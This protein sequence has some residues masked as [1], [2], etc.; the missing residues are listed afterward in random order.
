M[1]YINKLNAYIINI[2]LNLKE[3]FLKYRFVLLLSFIIGLLINS[4]DI[5]TFKFGI[6]NVVPPYYHFIK[7]RYGSLIL[8]KLFPFLSYNHVS[9]I[10]GVIALILAAL[11]MISKYKF[12]NNAKFLFIITFISAIYF[13]H[14]QYFF[15]QS[16]YNFIG[17]LFAVIAFRLIENNKKIIYHILAVFLLFTGITSYQSN[18]AVFL[19]TLMIGVIL[20][21]IDNKNIKS[22][23]YKI[24]KGIIIL[25]ITILIYYIVMKVTSTGI[26]KS[27]H[28]GMI[29]W[30]HSNADYTQI[31]INLLKFIFK[32]EIW[33]ILFLAVSFIYS[34]FYFKNIKERIFFIVLAVLFILAVFSFNILMGNLMPLRGRTQLAVLPAFTF[35]LIYNFKNYAVLKFLVIIACIMNFSINSSKNIQEQTA[36]KVGYEQDRMTVSKIF[37][38]IYTKYPEIYKDKYNIVFY[39]TLPR[40]NHVLKKSSDYM[41]VSF[42]THSARTHWL[43][44]V[45][46]LPDNIKH[47]NIIIWTHGLKNAPE[48]VKKIIR[49]MPAYPH[50]DCVYKY[51][52]TIIVKLSEY[53]A[54]LSE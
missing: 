5:F 7:S 2:S 4:V 29:Y 26:N 54:K 36:Y 14:L 20:D 34:L 10:A 27:H 39:G 46:G 48:E 15:F 16:A 11:L 19:S 45:S 25:L 28:I 9:Q 51:D 42:F 31:T 13:I 17:L 32:D 21:F 30:L 41:K 22:S 23:I 40:N 44:S 49:E 18:F 33:T 6:D 35:L 53:N 50:S 8:Y 47:G 1:E 52:N 24:F 3:F 12:S 37:D 43:L 38:L